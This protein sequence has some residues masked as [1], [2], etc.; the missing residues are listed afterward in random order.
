MLRIVMK[1]LVLSILLATLLPVSVLPQKAFYPSLMQKSSQKSRSNSG[2][3]EYVSNVGSFAVMIPSQG[4]LSEEKTPQVRVKL[5][6]GPHTYGVARLDGFKFGETA[7]KTV[8][9][10]AEDFLNSTEGRLVEKKAVSLGGYPGA[11]IKFETADP[12]GITEGRFYLV[13][14][15]MYAVVAFTREGS[16]HDDAGKFLDS[17]R[18]L[19]N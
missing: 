19:G 6:Q 16:S 11:S 8:E 7:Q 10:A 3:K 17:F 12:P 14:R 18:V 2:W 4:Q 15:Y 5:D 1:K 9:G 13:G